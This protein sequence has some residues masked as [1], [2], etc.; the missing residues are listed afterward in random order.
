MSFPQST[1]RSAPP[2]ALGLPD[3]PARSEVARPVHGAEI[4]P[5]AHERRILAIAAAVRRAAPWAV[6]RL[7][8]IRALLGDVKVDLRGT[9]IPD[10]CTVDVRAW[11]GNVT[12]IV[13]PGIDVSFDVFAILGNGICQA[14]EPLTPGAAARVLQVTGTA[15]LGEV[16]VLVR[17]SAT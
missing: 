9:D 10:G 13:P 5:V 6:P 14:P 17:E 4:A 15:S 3:H 12:V 1:P 16:R 7:L 11:G 2:A 8:R